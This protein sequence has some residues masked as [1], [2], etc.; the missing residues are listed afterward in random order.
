MSTRSL[1]RAVPRDPLTFPT[2]ARLCP[3]DQYRTTLSPTSTNW[4]RPPSRLFART[5]QAVPPA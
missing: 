4:T 2:L 3:A 1:R 5:P